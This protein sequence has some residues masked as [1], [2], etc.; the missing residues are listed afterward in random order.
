[1][2]APVIDLI[3]III[4]IIA[5]ISISTAINLII[6]LLRYPLQVRR[7]LN[8]AYCTLKKIKITHKKRR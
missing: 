2:I 3:M 7:A 8:R 5:P 4:G 6:F 1:M